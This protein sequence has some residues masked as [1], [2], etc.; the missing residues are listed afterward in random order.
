MLKVL[1]ISDSLHRGGA[2][3]LLLDV[4][5]NS[6]HSGLEVSL[7][8]TREGD[9]ENEFN[10]L[11]IDKYK[12]LRK[13]TLDIKLIL[14]LRKIIIEKEIKIIH[15]HQPVAAIHA[16]LSSF[17]LNVK[18]ILSIH[19]YLKNSKDI[20]A[21]N[22]LN[23]KLDAI[24]LPSYSFKKLILSEGLYKINK[25]V[26]IIYNGIDLSRFSKDNKTNLNNNIKKIGTVGNFRTEKD[27]YTLC[28]AI[29]NILRE[30]SNI[31]IEFIGGAMENDDKYLIK[32]KNYCYENNLQDYVEFLGKRSDIPK[33]LSHLDVFVLP[34]IQESFGIAAIEAM[35][36]K[37]PTVLSNIEPFLE[38]SLNGKNAFIFKAKN[39][40]DLSEK[41]IDLLK[42]DDKK[43]EI[44]ESAYMHTYNNYS[45]QTHI[46]ELNKLYKTIIRS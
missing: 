38:I 22:F 35:A 41:I 28:K 32:C 1:H 12:I 43:N 17:G 3:T 16:Y 33:F 13:A 24:I 37:I 39:Y 10:N 29:P 18:N 5:R 2:E 27:Q 9:L 23:K 26:K 7:I 44:I 14:K 30:F 21:I 25:N 8:V 6:M 4:C 20:K 36:M 42:N 40:T 31:K 19:G 15:S 34:S 11:N 46:E 45:I